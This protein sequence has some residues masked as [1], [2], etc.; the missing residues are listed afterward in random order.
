MKVNIGNYRKNRKVKVQIDSWDTWSLD[1]TLAEIIHPALIKFKEEREKMSGVPG[2]FFYADDPVDG[3]GNHTDEALEIA[4]KRFTDFL[5]DCIWAFGE[6]KDGYPE[7]DKYYI[8][9]PEYAN[10]T[11]DERLD[12]NFK[13][14]EKREDGSRAWISTSDFDREG[15][16]NY[17]KRLQSVLTKFGENFQTL[18]W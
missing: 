5:D 2:N 4:S 8:V 16:Q 17:H 6:I 14:K 9:K 7:E 10:L 3:N 12:I 11:E 18:W 13:K 1:S 15:F